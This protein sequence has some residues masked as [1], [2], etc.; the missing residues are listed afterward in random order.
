MKN[1]QKGFTLP[2]TL[3]AIL[4]LTTSIAAFATVTQRGLSSAQLSRD[5][6]T[7]FYLAQEGIE[8]VRSVRDG[9]KL[10]NV[11]WLTSF[12]FPGVS[13][14]VS[15][16]GTE[17]C[18]FSFFSN[19]G[20]MENSLSRIIGRCNPLPCPPLEYHTTRGVYGYGFPANAREITRFTRDIAIVNNPAGTD[21]DEAEIR[22]TVSWSTPSGARSVL[23]V[24][25]IRNL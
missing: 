4:I 3:I 15:P 11:N 20:D 22:V 5:Q 16:T 23:L 12:I 17:H 6:I 8:F 2:E 10:A 25:Q 9:N 24:E 19:N 13:D 7:A 14:C 1:T 21:P 18:L